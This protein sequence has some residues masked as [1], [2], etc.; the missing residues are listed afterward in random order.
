MPLAAKPIVAESETAT[1]PRTMG[2]REWA[3]LLTLAL[4]WGGS[5]FFAKLALAA[6]PPFT[7]VLG[8]VGIAALA[9]LAILR[10]CG[11]SLPRSGRPWRAFLAMGALNNAIPFSLIVWGQTEIASGLAA[12]L[13]ATTPLFTGLLAHLLTR[14]ERL[15]GLRLAGVLLG[16]LGVVAMIGPEALRGWSAHLLG[17]VAVLAAAISYACAGLFGRRFRG[18]PPLVTAAGQLIGSSLMMLPAALMVDRP[19]TLTAP[20]AG[21]LAALGALA[22]VCTAAAYV[23]YF[24]ILAASGATNLLLVTFL[25]PPSALVLGWLFLGERLAA[26]AFLGLALI[27]LGLAAFDGRLLARR[28][29]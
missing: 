24:R 12:I 2:A 7:V 21:S 26:G 16:F 6:L 25:I 8:R 13:N 18:T 14:D 15:T 3:L 17:E 29:A 28:R 27:A 9:L 11:H 22:L 1:A 5:F 4:L 19:W 20:S 10:A 23:I